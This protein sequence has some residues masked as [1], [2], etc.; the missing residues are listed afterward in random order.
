MKTISNILIIFI[1]SLFLLSCSDTLK[2][3]KL[4]KKS[5]SGDE[6]LIQKKDP[7]VLPPDFS[8]L[9]NPDEEVKE[10]KSEDNEESQIEMLLKED[11]SDVQENVNSNSPD[12]GLKKSILKKIQKQ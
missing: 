8:K 7:L 3:F 2:G 11:N 12:S 5:T 1:T 9:P 4:K 6:F 10:K